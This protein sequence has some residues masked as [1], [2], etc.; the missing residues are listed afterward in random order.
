MTTRATDRL[1]DWLTTAQAA[2][3]LSV[4]PR[5]VRQL[6]RVEQRLGYKM[7]SDRLMLVKR[8]DVERMAG[9]K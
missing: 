7:V 3:L 2:E 1:S 4:T 9:A 6:A 8:I 5:R